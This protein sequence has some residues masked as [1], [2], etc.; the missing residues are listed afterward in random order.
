MSE[1]QSTVVE[2]PKDLEKISVNYEPG[3]STDYKPHDGKVRVKHEHVKRFLASVVGA[4]VAAG[5]TGDDAKQ[6]G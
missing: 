5:N 1:A 6:G 4:K 2:V 3:V